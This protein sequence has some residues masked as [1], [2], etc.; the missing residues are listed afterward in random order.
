[1]LVEGWSRRL[2]PLPGELLTSCLARNALAH[3]TTPYR[4]LA[5]FWHGDPVWERDFDRDP[6][7]LLRLSRRPSAPDWLADVAAHLG[8]ARDI[9]EDAT[10]MD[11]RVRL[12]G[13]GLTEL[14][15][16]PLM[17]SA[18]VHHRT[19]KRHALQFCPECLAEATAYFRKVWRLGFVVSCARHGT[20][21]LDGCPH[22]DAP[23]VPHR[24]MTM[25]M[26]DCHDCGRSILGRKG[27]G[28]GD[29]VP[30]SVLALQVSLCEVL[31]GDGRGPPGPW[32]GLEAFEVTRALLAVLASA[33][34][35]A[36]LRRS[37]GLAMLPAHRS[38]RIRFEQAR[39]TDR[40][41]HLD[42]VAGWMVDWPAAFRR[43]AE[44]AGL[45]RRT[46]ARNHLSPALAVEVAQLPD[47]RCWK[48]SS[49]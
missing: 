49:C 39:L 45:S 12:G 20:R 15:D 31:S 44:A 1:V 19:R 26:T 38:G 29:G 17:Q 9:V 32:P 28:K 22:C 24:T 16:T 4:F 42:R 30:E 11:M 36:R 27:A 33:P 5:L 47:G 7:S 41:P 6:A 37:L 40:V 46:F 13:R 14:G 25:R 8:V 2:P 48:R 23:V 21:L 10:L 34:V 35:Y 43:G 3:G 18:G